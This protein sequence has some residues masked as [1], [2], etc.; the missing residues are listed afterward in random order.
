MK[1]LLD[2]HIWIWALAAPEKLGERIAAALAD[3]KNEL[4]LSPISLWEFLTLV[5][6]NRLVVEGDP[7]EW[8]DRALQRAPMR[9]AAIT[10]QIVI[11][12]QR[13]DLP[14]WDP[15]DRF[16]AA[17]ARCLGLALVTADRKLT[18]ARGLEVVS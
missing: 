17:T 1:L 4:W 13:L 2:T 10:R 6:K 16:I 7:Y 15:A 9:E 12:S 14:H 11:E 8:L 5:R 18:G 3:R